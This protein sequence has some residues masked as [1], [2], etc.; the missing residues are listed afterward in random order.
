MN[1]TPNTDIEREAFIKPVTTN[2]IVK[3]TEDYFFV[4][5]VVD[6]LDDIYY[7]VEGVSVPAS[8]FINDSI[9]KK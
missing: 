6:V 9:P 8:S 3:R 2:S 1:N 5:R 7:L 4:T